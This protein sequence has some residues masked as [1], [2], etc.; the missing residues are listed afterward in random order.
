LVRGLDPGGGAPIGIAAAGVIDRRH[1]IVRES[2]NFPEWKDFALAKRLAEASGRR[3]HLE[4]DANA[5][6]YGEMAC[7]AARGCEDI[8][9]YTLGTGVGGGIILGGELWRGARGMAGEL[10]HVTV[11]RDGGRPCGCGNHGCLEQY[12]GAVGIRRTLEERGGKL[13]ELADSRD[14]PRDLAKAADAGDDEARAVFAEIGRHLGVAAAAAIHTLDVLTIVLAGGIT[15]AQHLFVPA[16]EAEL[17]ARTFASMCEG[18]RVVVGTLG[19]DAGVLGA[20]ALA[21]M[22]AGTER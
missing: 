6:I 19:E 2:P 22:A 5:V 21:R 7:G 20:A 17:R 8:V 14:A 18:V 13:A 11:V 9:G 10:G 3:V 4:N 16:L 15:H 12:V 1:G